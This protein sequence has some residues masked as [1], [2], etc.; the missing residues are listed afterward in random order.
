MINISLWLTLA[1][2]EMGSWSSFCL[3]WYTSIP[4][5]NKTN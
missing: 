1:L 5:C 3:P 2:V 4:S